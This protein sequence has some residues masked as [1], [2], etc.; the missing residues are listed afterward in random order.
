MSGVSSE[1]DPTRPAER[2]S[3]L[4]VVGGDTGRAFDGE[5]VEEET[6]P[7]PHRLLSRGR[8]HGIRVS[9]VGHDEEEMVGVLPTVLS[10][11]RLPD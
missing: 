10:K 9:E 1:R 7:L 2:H 4:H 8:E 5:G 6:V 11:R 3:L